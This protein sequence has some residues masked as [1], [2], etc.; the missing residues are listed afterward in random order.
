MLAFDDTAIA[1]PAAVVEAHESPPQTPAW[2]PAILYA[3]TQLALQR[4]AEA[5]LFP[6]PFAETRLRVIG[7]H[8]DEAYTQPPLFDPRTRAFEWDHDPWTINVIGH[9]LMGSELYLHARGCRFGVAGSLGFAAVSTVAWEYVIEA[10]GTRPS[11]W[12]LAYTPVMGIALGEARYRTWQV[13]TRIEDATL[14][15]VVRAVVDPF[16]EFA[17]ALGSPC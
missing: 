3:S 8:Y 13:A 5:I 16:G 12:D 14:R 4:T 15:T 10:N 11:A 1:D 17:R 9:G 2:T 6:D 7:Q